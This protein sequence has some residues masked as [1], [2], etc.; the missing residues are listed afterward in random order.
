VAGAIYNAMVSAGS[1]YVGS[2]PYV[3]TGPRSALGHAT[4]ERNKIKAKDLVFLEIGGSWYRYGG[5][6]MRTVSVGKPS[7][8]VKKAAEAV[9]GALEALLAAVK[10]GVTSGDIDRR[11]GGLGQVL[12]PPHRLFHRRRLPAGLGRRPYHGPEAQ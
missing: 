6:I 1:E 3:V 11:E 7:A 10:P 9:Q 5:A 2:Q 4:F 8:D 12:D